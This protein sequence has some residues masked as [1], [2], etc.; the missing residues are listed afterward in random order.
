MCTA[1]NNH[2][3]WLQIS[4]NKTLQTKALLQNHKM[5]VLN[6]NEITFNSRSQV[7]CSF[8]SC[9]SPVS[10]SRQLQKA[11]QRTKT[12]GEELQ[13]REARKRELDKNNETHVASTLFT[14][15][16]AK[17]SNNGTTGL[18][19][20]ILLILHICTRGSSKETAAAQ[21]FWVFSERFLLLFIS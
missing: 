13:K 16:H 7:C 15:K 14:P 10:L 18:S 4:E 19:V 11:K 17:T 6:R 2:P 3:C 1:C 21:F 12:A 8:S 5:L 20:F 9:L